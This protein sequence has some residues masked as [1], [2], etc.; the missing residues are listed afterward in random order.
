MI[1]I[2]LKVGHHQPTS[3]TPFLNGVSLVSGWCLTIECW[4]RSFMN[5]QGIWAII[6]K[7]PV[8]FVIFKGW[9]GG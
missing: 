1:Q 4:L 7:E 5:L 6:N 8:N 9:G 2:P 3:E